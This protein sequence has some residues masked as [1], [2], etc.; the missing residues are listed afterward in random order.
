MTLR[1]V[2]IPVIAALAL[3]TSCSGNGETARPSPDGPPGPAPESR[4]DMDPEKY[5]R[6]YSQADFEM[7]GTG[8][9]NPAVDAVEVGPTIPPI[10]PIEPGIHDDNTFVNA[11]ENG[12][13]AVAEQQQSTFAL[14]VD[15]GSLSVGRTFLE[16]A[17]TLPPAD[18]VRVEEWV[19]AL[20][21]AQAA[22]TDTDLGVELTGTTSPFDEVNVLR[23]GVAAREVAT[24]D[25]PPANITFVVDT[26]GSMD[27][28][29]RLGLVQSSLA[30]LLLNLN[31]GDTISVVTFD[32]QS[33]VLLEPTPVEDA[34]TIVAAIDSLGPGGGTNL[35]AGLR[36]GYDLAQ[37]SFSEGAINAVILASDGVAN[38]GITD[39]DALVTQ[40]RDRADEGI[41]LVTVGYGM[42][43][44]NDDL[45][46]Q[47][48]N[49]GDGFYAYLDTYEEAERLFG[50]QLTSL[51]TI[52]AH[53]AKI[54]VEFATDSVQ[55]YRLLGY[56]NRA[57]DAEDFDDETVDA[58]EIGAGHRV[59]ALYEV[60]LDPGLGAAGETDLE[61]DPDLVLGEVSLRYRSSATAEQVTLSEP[62]TMAMFAGSFESAEPG[63]RL[64]VA[65]AAFADVLRGSSVAAER[66][67]TV[68]DAHEVAS[69]AAV[70]LPDEG[71]DRS[72]IV[73]NDLV[74]LMALAADLPQPPDPGP[75]CGPRDQT[76]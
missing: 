14:D 9:A 44:Y 63:F 49:Q 8:A 64:Q 68:A 2:L 20:G 54:Q 41:H 53:D 25:R 75:V 61:M 60:R 62:I 33:A 30:L 19:N 29:E 43:N 1:R 48:A 46:E 7:H 66:S 3:V 72:A 17:G 52:V 70:D 51:L 38:V 57:L 31:D 56:E 24:E 12:F 10:V 74:A 76:C 55:S 45:M 58:G 13:V 26:S 18:S 16:E 36:T 15:T 35:E 42:G 69:A 67:L 34:Q 11:G 22:P 65:T 6:E 21:S 32:E 40:I 47:L 59:T 28:R 23:V 71:F 50:D 4:I 37:S 39:P 27:I 5:V 73:P